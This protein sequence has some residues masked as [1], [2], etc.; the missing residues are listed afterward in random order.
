MT[1]L[2]RLE[3]NDMTE[4]LSR[5]HFPIRRSTDVEGASRRG[6]TIALA[7][8]FSQVDAYKVAMVISELGRNIEHYAGRGSITL[9]PRIGKNRCIE[10]VAQ[11]Q[12]PGIPNVERALAGGYS[13]SNGLGLGLLVSRHLMDEFELESVVGK[14]T[15][16]KAIKSLN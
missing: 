14:G 12:G 13:T 15:T 6:M 7:I 10:I 11:D 16:I 5:Q 3:G 2:T 9:I 4:K 1:A 8:G